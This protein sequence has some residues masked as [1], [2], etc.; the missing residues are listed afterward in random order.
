EESDRCMLS[1][2]HRSPLDQTSMLR[3]RLEFSLTRT[4][5]NGLNSLMMLRLVRLLTPGTSRARGWR[6]CELYEGQANS[7]RGLLAQ[8]GGI[9]FVGQGRTLEGRRDRST[10][11][12]RCC[13]DA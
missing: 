2:S 13:R 4:L 11:R 7:A 9:C 6:W 3:N 8:A 1:L 5:R 12:W 10:S